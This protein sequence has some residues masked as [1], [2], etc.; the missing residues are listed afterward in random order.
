MLFVCVCVR[1]RER[2]RD[3]ILTTYLPLLEKLGQTKPILVIIMNSI[4]TA[5]GKFIQNTQDYHPL[6][7][8]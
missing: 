3:G 8:D 5:R 4:K 6:V 2:E 7:R 1:E